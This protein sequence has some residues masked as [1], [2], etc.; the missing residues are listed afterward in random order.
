M[1]P[2][3]DAIDAYNTAWDLAENGDFAA[4][5]VAYEDV[6]DRYRDTPPGGRLDIPLDAQIGRSRALGELGRIEEGVAALDDALAWWG[7]EPGAPPGVRESLAGAFDL[8]GIML[9]DL[10]RITEALDAFDE[11]VTRFGEDVDAGVA[12]MVAQ[13]L[14]SK[15]YV[16]LDEE[17]AEEALAAF[18]ALLAYD[19]EPDGELRFRRV[20]QARSARAS[21]LLDVGRPQEALADYDA[22]IADGVGGHD[23]DP[24]LVRW[25]VEAWCGRAFCLSEQERWDEAIAACDAGLAAAEG[26][27]IEGAALRVART[28]YNKA[29]SLHAL[30]RHADEL[31]VLEALDARF[32]DDEDPEVRQE[33][34]DALVKRIATLVHLARDEE[35]VA[36]GDALI[37]RYGDATDVATRAEVA[38]ACRER[39][40]ALEVLSRFDDAIAAYR[41]TLL[42]FGADEATD[43]RRPV[44]EAMVGLAWRLI[45]RGDVAEG[46]VMLDAYLDG[47]AADHAAA[48][49][50]NVAWAQMQKG[51]AL[52]DLERHAEAL[53]AYDALIAWLDGATDVPGRAQRVIALMRRAEMLTALG[54]ADEVAENERAL[55]A[56]AGDEVADVFAALAADLGSRDDPQARIQRA[57]L[58]VQE[59]SVHRARGEDDTARDLLKAVVARFG[60][61][62]LPDVQRA[63]SAARDQLDELGGPDVL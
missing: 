55:V 8:K 4:A 25:I 27:E 32:A 33:V 59:A 42:R 63:V 29:G 48:D 37:A 17:R 53:A 20:A 49:V 47:A 51:T 23:D 15:A 19:G 38:Y 36:V 14:E 3:E 58:I 57:E 54:R 28:M 5:L 34:L 1:T 35:A 41:D 62:A 46:L 7:D 31:A 56:T 10:G 39:A 22:A 16:L 44:L 61:D 24:Y 21:L 52:Q 11:A 45:Q 30:R 26:L 43:V 18:A 50:T 6:V 13:V 12:R 9:C 40:R 2:L 60:D